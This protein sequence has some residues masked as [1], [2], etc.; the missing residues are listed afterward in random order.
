MM[1]D[2]SVYYQLGFFDLIT[3]DIS[4]FIILALAV[5]SNPNRDKYITFMKDVTLE[6]CDNSVEKGLVSILSPT[7]YDSVTKS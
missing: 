3:Q 7:I 1:G 4:T 2:L 5:V 6:Q